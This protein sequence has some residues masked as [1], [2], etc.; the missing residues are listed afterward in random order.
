M[1][2]NRLERVLGDELGDIP[3]PI[4]AERIDNILTEP[5]QERLADAIVADLID[6]A[7]LAGD[8]L[9]LIRLQ[10]AEKE[11]IEYPERPAFVEN[12]VSDLPPPVDTIGDLIISQNVL[13]YLESEQGIPVA[14]L[15]DELTADTAVD[16]DNFI[17]GALGVTDTGP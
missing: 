3:D 11:D 6:A 4:D 16:V 14:A 17:E 13:H 2:A 1:S 7:P 9:A 15:P 12:V 5:A 10:N 8:M